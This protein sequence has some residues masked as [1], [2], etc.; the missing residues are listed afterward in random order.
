MFVFIRA[1]QGGEQQQKSKAPVSQWLK[2]LILSSTNSPRL[3][4]AHEAAT[5]YHK[6]LAKWEKTQGIAES[7]NQGME[8]GW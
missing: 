1:R 3:E 2:K 4:N 7:H 5:A 8:D 6:S